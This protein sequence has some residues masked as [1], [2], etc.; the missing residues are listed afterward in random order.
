[1]WAYTK[2]IPFND[3]DDKEFDIFYECA[4]H[5]G[6]GYKG[7]SQSQCQFIV[8]LLSKSYKKIDEEMD[9]AKKLWDEYGCNILTDG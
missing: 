8:S 2:G 9:K 5:R 3:F 4:G 6:P 7:P 1:M